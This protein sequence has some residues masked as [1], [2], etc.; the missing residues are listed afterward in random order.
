MTSQNPMPSTHTL[1]LSLLRA[2]LWGEAPDPHLFAD[3]DWD[4]VF[5]LAD[6]ETV[7]AV[8]MDGVELLPKEAHPPLAMKLKRI[9]AMQQVEKANVKHR[10]VM[11]R[12]SDALAGAEISAVFMKGQTVGTRYPVPL[13]RQPGDIDFVVAERDFGRTLRVLEGLGTVDNTMEHEHHGTAWVDGVMVEPHYKVHN[14]QRPSTDRAM[15]DMFG[16][17]FPGR[18]ETMVIDGHG[19]S[20]FPPTFE[21]VFLISHIVEHVYGEGVGLRQITDYALFMAREHNAID[22]QLH[23]RW[24][25]RMRMHRAWRIVTC[26]CVGHLGL[27]KPEAIQPFTD[28]ERSR[29][30]LLLDDILSVGNF[31]RGKYVFRYRGMADAARNYLWVL[32]RCRKMWFVCPSEA[33]WWVVAKAVR[34]VR[35]KSREA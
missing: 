7:A 22:W 33:R 14:Y 35:K 9:G 1:F 17:V 13:H 18:L 10:A 29:A 4:A 25:R 21:S 5:R 28:S 15:R 19:I 30:S 26:L 6:I 32:G 34:F 11:G 12:I 31:G 8:V 24:L 23:D 20:V 2:A 27:R 16:E 3:A